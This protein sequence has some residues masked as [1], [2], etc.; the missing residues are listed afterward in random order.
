MNHMEFTYIKKTYNVPACTGRRVK[1]YGKPGTIVKDCGH[2]LG[3][4]FDEDKPSRVSRAHPVDGVEY[5][6]E[7]VKP[8]KVGRSAK[9]YQEWLNADTG[10]SFANWIGADRKAR[11]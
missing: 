7:I 4:N 6:T 11:R 2:H 10:H 3:V 8:R 5:L 1:V 9:R